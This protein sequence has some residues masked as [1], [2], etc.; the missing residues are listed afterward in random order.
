ML[1]EFTSPPDLPSHPLWRDR[2]ALL[3]GILIAFAISALF[4][5]NERFDAWA[6]QHEATNVDELIVLMTGLAV[7]ALMYLAVAHR[8]LKVEVAIRQTRE[9]AALHEVEILS[10]LLAMCS[11][12]KRIRDENNHWEPVEIYL[13][14]Q[15]DGELSVSHGICP[16]CTSEL[17][18]DHAEAMAQPV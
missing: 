14:Q 13:Q 2:V 10:S 16:E 7:V 12:C 15:G 8:R 11:S 17:Y 4:D 3:A 5:L 9:A 1:E 6:A 18:P